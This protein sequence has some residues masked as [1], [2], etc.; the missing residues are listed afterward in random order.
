MYGHVKEKLCG[1]HYCKVEMSVS[2]R[3]PS[4]LKPNI[5]VIEVRGEILDSATKAD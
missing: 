5:L 3:K 4:F 2:A 1:D